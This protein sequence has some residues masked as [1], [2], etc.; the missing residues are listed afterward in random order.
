[1]GEEASPQ[2]MK[3]PVKVRNHKRGALRDLDDI[4]KE[5]KAMRETEWRS[6][7]LRAEER[8]KKL[9][10]E[11][12]YGEDYDINKENVWLRRE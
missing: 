5:L 8:A 9:L 3:G 4:E 11:M 7:K 6:A 10:E 2:G 1:M 12:G